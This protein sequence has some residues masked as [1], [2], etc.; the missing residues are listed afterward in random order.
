MVKNSMLLQ[1]YGYLGIVNLL[2]ASSFS[3]ILVKK[4]S[5]IFGVLKDHQHRSNGQTNAEYTCPC[6]QHMCNC[7]YRVIMAVFLNRYVYFIPRSN[8]GITYIHNKVST[9]ICM[10]V[11]TFIPP[12]CLHLGLVLVTPRVRLFMM[13][14]LVNGKKLDQKDAPDLD[15]T[16]QTILCRCGGSYLLS[17]CVS[18]SDN[19]L[20]HT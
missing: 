12:Q 20:I 18:T 19:I 6:R 2:S 13:S 5:T 17:Y 9:K 1:I 11:C 8:F 7:T 16:K 15:A 10:Y 3:Y 4:I 14:Y